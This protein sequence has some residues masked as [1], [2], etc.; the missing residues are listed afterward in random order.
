M[1]LSDFFRKIPL[2]A[3]LD[4]DDMKRLCSL[5][6]EVQLA[7]GEE[8][9]AE[10]SLGER[11]YIVEDGQVEVIKHS[12]RREVKVATVGRGEVV[13]ELAL[14]ENRPRSATV[15]ART[16]ALLWAIDKEQLLDLLRT[17]PSAAETM[18]FTVLDR[19]RH[20]ES[21]LRQSEKM[22]QLGTLAAGV[23][24]ELNNPAAAVRRGAVQLEGAIVNMAQAFVRI[25]Q[26][27]LTAAQQA[28]LERLTAYV[29]QQ[30]TAP[31]HLDA[32]ARSDRE[33]EV[34]AWLEAQGVPDAWEVAPTMVNLNLSDEDLESLTE[35]FTG[36]GGGSGLRVIVTWL[37][38]NYDTFNL[39]AEL[40]QGAGRIAD[41]VMA[42]KSYAYL[43]QAPVQ[44][45][46]V[47]KGL[48][49]TLLILRHKLATGIDVQREYASN[50]PVIEGYGSELN[51]VW[52]NLIDNAIDAVS[53]VLDGPVAEPKITVST[54]LE[55]DPEDEWVVVTIYDNGPGI[56]EE[57]LPK[58]FDPFFTTKPPGQGTG[59]GLDISYNIVVNKHGGEIRVDSEPGRTAFEVWL[60]VNYESS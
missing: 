9:F 54:R 11:A 6:Q 51:Q 56:P 52:T 17:S 19:W 58:L 55:G 12:N 42:L 35:M 33:N 22:A 38:A 18:F 44:Q 14:L 40:R 45:V 43:D 60:P 3:Q 7:A 8:L 29:R 20:T 16:G 59:L 49:D 57:A 36:S 28:E 41:I 37:N 1:A 32:L 39:L 53:G 10:G 2:F 23:A 27:K 5:A 31:L 25:I 24:H 46:D 34:E 4:A 47:H 48:D 15:R 13:G 50:L 30:A 21:L 26:S